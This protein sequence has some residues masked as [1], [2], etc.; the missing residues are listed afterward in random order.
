MSQNHF[1]LSFPLKSPVDANALEQELPP[2]MPDLFRAED[3]VGTVHYSRFTV[4]SDRMLLF[5]GDFDG[6]FGPLMLELARRAG[7]VFDAIFKHVNDPPSGPVASSA[8]AFVEW[9]AG[10]LLSPAYVYSAYPGPTVKEIKAMAS[11]ADIQGATQLY[12]FLVI[13]PAK[14]R[15]AF[16]EMQ[17]ILRT[18]G[19]T[20]KVDRDMD[21]VGTPHFAQFVPLEDQQL[22]FFTVYDGAFDKYIMDFTKNIGHVF[23]VIFKFTKDPPASPCRKH[24][25]EFIDFAAA[26]SRTP[27]GFYQAY[28]GLSNQDIKALIADSRAQAAAA[29]VS[30]A[31]DVVGVPSGSA[32]PQSPP[33]VDPLAS[34]D[35][36]S[37]IA[38]VLTQFLFKP[39][40]VEHVI[41]PFFMMSVNKGDRMSLPMIDV[42]LTKENAIPYY[43]LGLLNDN[44]NWRLSPEDGITVFIQALEKR[45]PDN[46]RKKIY[47]TAVTRDLYRPMYSTKVMLFLD[48]WLD[49]KNA[50]KPL[51]RPYLDGF[52][53]MY[54]DLHL[55]VKGDA[56]PAKVRQFGESFNNV[57]AYQDP[58]QKIVYENY[59]AA[60]SNLGFLKQWV[61]ERIADIVEGRVAHPEQT[62]VHYWIK[63]G[64]EGDDFKRR[65][66]V[67]ECFHNMVAFNQ[68]GYTLYLV[69]LRLGKNT[70][71]P[72]VRAWFKKT[73]ESNF[74]QARDGAF[75]PLDRL[76]MELFRTIS[77]NKGSISAL[78][79]VV[80]PPIGRHGY[81]INPHQAT[82]FDPLHWKDPE[83][84]NPDRY[85]AAPTSHQIDEARCREIGFAQC[86]FERR[87]FE[88]K[89]GRNAVV[90]NSAF[91]TVYGIVDGTPLPVCDYAG[92]APFGFGYRRCPG[93]QLTTQVVADFLR[94]VWKDK[95]E[96]DRLDIAGLGS[97]PIGG[98]GLVSDNIGF[99]RAA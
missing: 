6:D 18:M 17:L 13:L 66:V 32:V 55:G 74:D 90:Q 84:F 77:P 25:Q 76:V 40:Y 71:D 38:R 47:Q 29:P 58:T 93:E 11:A 46:R 2:L 49:A 22:G 75:T 23:D 78:S 80:P 81:I 67:F 86:P 59:M 19:M 65:D 95:I 79:E 83:A 31:A 56:I 1:T 44:E 41:A 43:L 70:G 30:A 92:F 48:K 3:A 20:G 21:S 35:T 91:G 88:V 52:F 68:W 10:H 34:I 73:M 53:D 87:P 94:K 27:I 15:L 9:A 50:G 16:A 45:G 57:F 99:T 98:A 26:A 60:R 4:L 37:V 7:P 28:P 54:W 62:F 72:D 96:F 39:A 12:P 36:R 33:V 69:M 61:N 14:G 85:N 24:V 89:D 5:L 64:E 97:V 8:D 82:S 42:T 51:M 63:N